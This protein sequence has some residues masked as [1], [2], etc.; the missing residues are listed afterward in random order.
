[1]SKYD[2]NKLRKDEGWEIKTPLLRGKTD[3]IDSPSKVY[4]SPLKPYTPSPVSKDKLSHA[5]KKKRTNYEPNIPFADIIFEEDHY[6]MD[7]E[8]EQKEIKPHEMME[9]MKKKLPILDTRVNQK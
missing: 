8:E 5:K 7:E 1:M 6:S 2:V 9:N 4:N 3:S